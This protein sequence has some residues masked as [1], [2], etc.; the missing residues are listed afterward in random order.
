[1]RFYWIEFDF[2][3]FRCENGALGAR[4]FIVYSSDAT[5][6]LIILYFEF[7]VEIFRSFCSSPH[8]IQLNLLLF[9]PPHPTKKLMVWT[10]DLPRL[11]TN[12]KH[13]TALI[14]SKN[15]ELVEEN[16]H[17][18]NILASSNVSFEAFVSSIRKVVEDAYPDEHVRPNHVKQ[19]LSNTNWANHGQKNTKFAST[20]VTVDHCLSMVDFFTQ[21]VDDYEYNPESVID[22]L[23]QQTKTKAVISPNKNFE[24]PPQPI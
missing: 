22:A 10:I 9:V 23:C 4:M 12:R 8:V 24:I 6:G 7:L 13:F 11:G 5:R 2:N 1:M 20:D 21:F 15:E 14:K 16:P 3:L 18:K 17:L 19:L